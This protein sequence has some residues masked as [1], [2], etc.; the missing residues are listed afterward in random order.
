[1]GI[2]ETDCTGRALKITIY[3]LNLGFIQQYYSIN[4]TGINAIRRRKKVSE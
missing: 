4:I 3:M 1:M 2:Y